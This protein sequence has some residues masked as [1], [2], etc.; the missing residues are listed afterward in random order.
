RHTRFSRDWSSDVCSS[1]LA[2]QRAG[3]ERPGD[4]QV[5]DVLG[6]DLVEL[7]EA[8]AGVV[9]TGQ[10]PLVGIVLELDEVLRGGRT[11]REQQPGR[12]QPS[13]DHPAHD[14]PPFSIGSRW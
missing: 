9:L 2:V 8:G 1:D 13:R 12:Y 5:L 10:H 4:L 14:S 7:A 3:R 11:D 6:V